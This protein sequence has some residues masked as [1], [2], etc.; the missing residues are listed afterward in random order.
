MWIPLHVLTNPQIA[1]K[2]TYPAVSLS[3]AI[4]TMLCLFYFV[5]RFFNENKNNYNNESFPLKP[6]FYLM[7]F[8]YF[9]SY[10]YSIVSIS[11]AF[12][13][14]I[15]YFLEGFVLLYA[16]HCCLNDKN[17]LYLFIKTAFVVVLLITGLGLYEFFTLDNPVLDYTYY[18]SPH[19]A[20]TSGRL[21]YFP[22]FHRLRYGLPRCLSFFPIH[23][24]F[25]AACVFFMLLFGSMY[26]KN[27]GVLKN[28]YILL[29]I[30]LLIS[31]VFASNSKQ[32]IVGLLF[33]S[34]CFISIQ[35][36]FNYK[37]LLIAV[38]V[39]SVLIYYPSII[40]NILSL[41]DTELA[42]EGK[43]STVS[44]RIQQYTVAFDMFKRNPIFGCGPGSLGTLKHLEYGYDAIRGAESVF[45]SLLPERGIIGAFVYIFMYFYLYNTLKDKMPKKILFF[46]LLTDIIY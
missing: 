4:T 11:S 23:L 6:V 33:I 32:G 15:R 31:G 18:N 2:Y 16:F 42:Q 24:R 25:G 12:N 40:N 29:C 43:G 19:N 9:V 34:L 1:L 38:F 22:G 10:I 37:L 8:S 20:Y 30:F 7:L 26:K 27:I 28:K 13:L 35:R 45:L 14:T 17:D 44:L 39:C 46:Y 21:A 5:N 36:M 3:I 41:F